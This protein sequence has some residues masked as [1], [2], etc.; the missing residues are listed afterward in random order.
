MSA[1]TSF[2]T[3]RHPIQVVARRA[4]LTPDALRAWERRYGA[5]TPARSDTGRRLYSDADIA[6]LILLKRLTAGGRSI[7]QIAAM[8][9]ESLEQLLQEDEA[10]LREGA[11]RRAVTPRPP[12]GDREGRWLAECFDAIE[13]Y[14]S[15]GLRSTL[16]AAALDLPPAVVIERIL[17]PL[18]EE[19]GSRW[20]DG[21][22][23]VAQEHLATASVQ[24]HLGELMRRYTPEAAPVIVVA[25]PCGQRHQMGAM[26][27]AATAV[28]QGWKVVYLGSD[29]PAEEIASGVVQSGA[30]AV[31]VSLVYPSDDPLLASELTTLR[32]L[33]PDETVFLVGGRSAPSYRKLL[34]QLGARII[35]DLAGLR[36]VLAELTTGGS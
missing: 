2:E 9:R 6:R 12:S 34:E 31:A 25:T 16:A 32:R 5:V 36:D 23:R 20:H 3:P 8:S 24:W 27:A 28:S 7:G 19:I 10:A 22:L 30:R 11:V 33:V 35:S 18:F 14:D 1:D 15:M 4:G 17:G 26:L 21:T 29:L 13:R